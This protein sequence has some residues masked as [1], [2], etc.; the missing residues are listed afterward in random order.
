MSQQTPP[1]G[2]QVRFNYGGQVAPAPPPPLSPHE[3]QARALSVLKA[4]E[5]RKATGFDKVRVGRDFDGGYILLDDFVAVGTALSIGISDDASWDL[6][7]AER[8]IPVH[9]FDH[10][11]ER[12][13]IGHPLITFHKLAVAA[14]D[15]PGALSLDTIVN[16]HLAGCERAILKIDIEGNEWQVFDAASPSALDRFSQIV[17]EFHA[18]Q[19]IGDQG[20]TELFRSVLDK[21]R[22]HFEVVHVHGNNA[23]PMVN[24]ANVA[25]PALLEVT[26]ANRRHYQFVETNEVFPTALDQPNIPGM[27]EMRL[28]CFKF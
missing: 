20:Y 2:Y 13:P 5:P 6:S 25:L 11:I 19:H 3:R 14:A 23:L 7:I 28:G 24:V 22:R 4:F 26:F 8:N 10:S 21:L 16:R 18:L 1:G 17:C 27:P 12:G 15:A 9:Q